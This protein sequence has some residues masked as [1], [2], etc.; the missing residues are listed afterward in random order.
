MGNRFGI[1]VRRW[2]MALLAVGMGVTGNTSAVLLDRG[3]DMVY[4]TVLDITWVRDASLCVTLNNCVNR[5]DTFL[6]GG[7]AWDES[8][9]LW[10][11]ALVFGG[12]DDWRLP[13]ASV[14]AGAGPITTLTFG[15]P[16]TGAGGADEVACRDNE[17]AYMFYYNLD[18]NFFDNKTGTQTA[19][20]DEELTGI[21]PVYWSGTEFGSNDAWNFHFFFGFQDDDDKL[22][23]LSAW[24][25]RPGD[26]AAAIP[27]A[28]SLL[29]FGLG[30]LGLGWLRR[31]AHLPGTKVA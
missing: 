6:T 20:G 9:V 5:D 3:P 10:A 26:L 25:V 13:Y 29:L 30:A 4:D 28:S 12:F 31:R 19:V 22:T 24:A 7:M 27:E 14:S 15:F 18:G 11:N 21:R 17:M 2:A 16:C 8:S 23:P 1:T